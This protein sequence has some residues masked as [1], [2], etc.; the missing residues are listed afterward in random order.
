M[1]VLVVVG[2]AIHLVCGVLMVLL[3]VVHWV[4]ICWTPLLWSEE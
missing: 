1:I 4:S 2:G 3:M